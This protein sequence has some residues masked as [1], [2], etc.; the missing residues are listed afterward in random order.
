MAARLTEARPT[1]YPYLLDPTLYPDYTRRPSRAPTWATF[2]GRP[3]FVALRTLPT[4]AFT[5]QGL[6]KVCMPTIA[7]SRIRNSA[8]LSM[9]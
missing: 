9:N 5:N 7:S 8:R 2:E 6:G 4:A 3:Q 1:V